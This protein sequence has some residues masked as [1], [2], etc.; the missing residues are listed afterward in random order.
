MK[1]ALIVT[2]LFLSAC[3]KEI[4]QHSER[5]Q[6]EHATSDRPG[7]WCLRLVPVYDTVII[8][9]NTSDPD[10]SYIVPGYVSR[11]SAVNEIYY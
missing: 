4:P 3:W 1:Q 10:H 2:A 6:V 7:G 5:W 11:D 9:W 8:N